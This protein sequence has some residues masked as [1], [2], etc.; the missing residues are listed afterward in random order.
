[1]KSTYLSARASAAP[2][3]KLSGSAA[4]AMYD[5]LVMGSRKQAAE[6]RQREAPKRAGGERAGGVAAEIKKLRGLVDRLSPN[7]PRRVDA[8]ARLEKLYRDAPKSASSSLSIDPEVTRSIMS[9]RKS[10]S[11]DSLNSAAKASIVKQ[12][13]SLEKSAAL[14]AEYAEAS[15][16]GGRRAEENEEQRS[17]REIK[18]VM[19]DM[20]LGMSIRRK[21]EQPIFS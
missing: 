10:L 2:E 4:E 14:A 13:K 18:E 1:M 15:G 9:L 12:I 5:E 6:R 7:D 19:S 16:G 17:E 21:A 11:D 3:A 20:T 8:V